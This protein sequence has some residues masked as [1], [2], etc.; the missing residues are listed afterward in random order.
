MNQS[1]IDQNHF[2]TP[3]AEMGECW[4]SLG[5]ISDALFK[6]NFKIQPLFGE[7]LLNQMSIITSATVH[8]QWLDS[9]ASCPNPSR[10]AVYHY[11]T[12][13]IQIS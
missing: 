4:G 11:C 7:P 5:E 6:R 13:I 10:F 3:K 2:S 9:V 1:P 12:L 8:I